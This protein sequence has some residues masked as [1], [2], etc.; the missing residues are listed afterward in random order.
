M[1]HWPPGRADS[2]HKDVLAS[3]AGH[4]STSRSDCQP[5]DVFW[6]AANNSRAS[7]GDVVPVMDLT[8]V[9]YFWLHRRCYVP[10]SS[11]SWRSSVLCRMNFKKSRSVNV[12]LDLSLSSS[13]QLSAKGVVETNVLRFCFGGRVVVGIW[14]RKDVKRRLIVTTIILVAT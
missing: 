8:R 12:R 10:G 2:V 5:E 9:W 1:S 4:M 14:E 7:A 11:S 3:P 6:D 13:Q